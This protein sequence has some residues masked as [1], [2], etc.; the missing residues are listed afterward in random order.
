MVEIIF[1]GAGAIGR[2]FLPWIFGTSLYDF[3]FIDA[4]LEVVKRLNQQKQYRAYRVKNNELEEMIVPVKAAY[5]PNDFFPQQHKDAIAVF[6]SVGPR[7]SLAAS[8]CIKG[9][10]CPIVLCENDPQTVQVVKNVTN[11]DRVYFAVPD[12]ITSNTASPEILARDPLSVITEDGVLLI[13]DRASDIKGNISFCSEGELITKQW[14]AKLYLHNT[15]HCI[16]AYLGALVGATYVHESMKFPTVKKIVTGSMSEMLTSLKLKW[17]ISHSFLD[18]YAEKETRRF[19]NELLCDPISRVARE[20]LR[21]LD[22]EGRLIGAAQICISL[23]F[24]P[25][26]ILI[27]ITSALLFE[28]EKDADSQL[29]FMRKVLTSKALLTYI[30]GLRKGEALEIVMRERL[31]KIV[32]QLEELIEESRKRIS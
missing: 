24:I 23:G 1:L 22:L 11:S 19:C 28:N 4:N 7:N 31:P 12:V 30:L 5:H 25:Q 29:C 13:D 18:W 17:D 10:K 16:A 14:T 27:G 3:V 26:N 9:M 20:P 21:K 2:G 15:S 6:I 32:S 8:A